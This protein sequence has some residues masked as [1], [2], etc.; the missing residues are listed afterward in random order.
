MDAQPGNQIN[1]PVAS[2][3]RFLQCLAFLSCAALTLATPAR[4]IVNGTEAG[5]PQFQAV[6]SLS[7]SCTGTFI[8]PRFILTAA[9]CIPECST[10]TDTGCKTSVDDY[11]FDGRDRPVLMAA[12][13]GV[14]PGTGAA[15]MIDFVFFPRAADLQR[16]HPTDNALLRTTSPFT[17]RVIPV[18]PHQDR[19]RPDESNY[20]PRWEFTWPS[21]LGFST[22]AQTVDARRRVG[23]AFAECDLERDERYFKLDGHGRPGQRGI[24][25]CPGD[26][27]GPVLWDTGFGGFAVG[28]TNTRTDDWR[29][30]T[31]T[32]C[33]SERGEGY[34]SFIPS[35]FL[36]RVAQTDAICAGSSGWEQCPGVPPPYRGFGLSYRGTE[37]D[38]CGR[39]SLSISSV[40]GPVEVVRG[41][42]ASAEV[43]GPRFN[44]FCG[45]SQEATT[46]RDGVNFV[47]AKRGLTDRRVIWDT[48]TIT[49]RPPLTWTSVSEGSSTPGGRVT[50]V[51]WGKDIALF[52]A[53][54]NGGIYTAL[55]NPQAGFGAWR[56]VSEGSST[57]GGRVTAV[58]WGN[59]IALFI[60]D[61]NGGI[62]TALGDPNYAAD[63]V[64]NG[65]NFAGFGPWR[66]VS[67]GSSTPGA[68]VMAIPWGNN[69]ALFIADRNGGIYTALGDPN[70]AAD[71]VDNGINFAGFG[72]WRSVSEGS[73]TPGGS[74]MA[75]RGNNIALF[76]ADRN[77]GIYT[78]SGDPNYAA[79]R[80][81]NGVNFAGFGGWGLVSGPLDPFRAAPGSPVTAVPYGGRFALFVA[82]SKGEIFA[83]R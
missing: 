15:F 25:L 78:A 2:L 21:V 22:N 59:N 19:P 11:T 28:G 40:D 50:A 52:T 72:P 43:D 8:H 80:V 34:H 32:R 17:G 33:P 38:E 30:I 7:S 83:G 31:D 44:W 61:P 77:G 70:Y 73:S 14:T 3:G 26:S 10:A 79:D 36:D 45:G 51:P 67:E 81:D 23:R 16:G 42:T 41:G 6:V 65:V 4:A 5:N 68:P 12:R 54:P 49:E 62:Y 47:V 46:A 57:P 56:S 76:I 24:R 53:D 82:N 1:S 75:I 48:Y 69:I 60:A 63:R 39:S 66:S 71:R 9:H 58:P 55:G 74:V 64:D 18:L 20:C 27:G 13:D 35:A 29:L 37:I